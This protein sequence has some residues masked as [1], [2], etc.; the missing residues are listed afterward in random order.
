[1][2]KQMDEPEMRET[3][4][5][6]AEWLQAQRSEPHPDPDL[7]AAFAENG[8]TK[9]NRDSL[10][11]HLA[12]CSDCRE[13]LYLA[14]PEVAEVQPG[15]AISR[16]RP[17]L[18]IRWATLAA[19]LVI[20][21]SVFISNRGLFTRHSG[22]NAITALNS[23]GPASESAQQGATSL[24][25]E[26]DTFS[27]Q[28]PPKSRPPLKHMTAKPKAAMKFDKSGQVYFGTAPAV[29][30]NTEYGVKSKI[31]V[32]ATPSWQLSPGGGVLRSLDGGKSWQTIPV[33]EGG[34]FRVINSI[35]FAVWVGGNAGA[36]YHS[37]DQGEH[38]TKVEPAVGT[39]K[40]NSDITQITFSDSSNGSIG[41]ANG[42]IW[43][44]SDSGKNWQLK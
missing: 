24:T 4:K 20:I 17:R 3:K 5:F 19:S 32:P 33:V 8:L 43:V 26:K 18:A 14:M 22:E 29:S 25:A 39:H 31:A 28:S 23:P 42:E 12:A 40:L 34:S 21:G 15:F 38:W 1:V 2:A 27:T 41:T 36:L 37:G 10:L 11:A 35:G 30:I 9:S 7:L 6:V 44:T 13:V 16:K